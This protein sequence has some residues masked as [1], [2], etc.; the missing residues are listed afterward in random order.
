MA[1]QVGIKKTVYNKEQFT[2]IVDNT[3]TT[4]KQPV[5]EQDPD[6]IE[7]L[8]RLYDKLYFEIDLEG[9]TQSHRYLVNKS[10]ELIDFEANTEEIQPLLDEIA[11][12]REQ[13]LIAN[14]QII[15]LETKQK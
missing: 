10:L 15:D 11:Q 5:P 7:E 8:F 12:L 2:K 9:Q 3:F 13:L 6:T 4:Y 14:Q 1:K